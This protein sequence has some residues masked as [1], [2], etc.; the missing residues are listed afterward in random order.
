MRLTLATILLTAVPAVAQVENLDRGH[1]ILIE[2]GF[3]IQA[4]AFYRPEDLGL[5]SYTFDSAPFLNAGFTTVNWQWTPKG[6]EIA[7]AFPWGRWTNTDEA[8]LT[9]AELPFKSSMATFLAGE[10]NN[11]NDPG[12]RTRWQNWFAVARPNFPNTILHTKQLAFDATPASLLTYM[13]ESR[14]DMLFMNSYR[15]KVGNTEGTWHLFSDLQRYRRFALLGNDGTGAR[16]IPYGTQTQTFQGENLYRKPSESELRMH[17]FGAWALGYKV[18]SAFT[19]NYGTSVLFTP[20]HDTSNPTDSYGQVREVNRQGRNLGPAL[21]RLLSRD[22]L[23]IPGQHKDAGG[24]IVTNAT[25][26]DM[27]AYPG[28]FNTAVK[29]PYIRGVQSI[30]NL[31][32]T[33]DGLKGDFL[34]SWFQLL[35]ESLDGPE[36]TGEWYFMVTNG[37]VDP[38][39]TA[40]ATSQ[41]I[42]LNFASNVPG[43]VQRLSRD[44]GLVEDVFMPIIP[45]SGGRRALVLELDGG[46]S[47]LFK[48][49]TGAPFVGIAAVPEPL[50][51]PLAGFAALL[52]HR[53][54][55]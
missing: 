41:T 43:Y 2:R 28:G 7:P 30:A 5:G 39:G 44:T 53:R 8:N 47:D 40:A 13:S 36:W 46:T 48:F 21:V 38:A 11:L 16:P 51:L 15:W 17:H 9:P 14:P 49:K 19:Y 29:D 50:G 33:N 10:E 55:R 24:N 3:Q 20:G 6:P 1:R 25:P 54:R 22:V 23:F 4:Q 34:L 35:D 27:A 18:T 37:L 31:G 45:S 12:V 26:I 32:T 52:L 42:Q